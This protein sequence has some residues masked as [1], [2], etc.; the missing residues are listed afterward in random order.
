MIKRRLGE[1]LKQQDWAGVAIELVLVVV[2]VF[3]GIQV[4][5][6]ND[7]RRERALERSYVAR[8]GQDVR[9]DVADLDEV[10]R[11]SALRMA[12]LNQLLPKASGQPLPSGFDSARGRVRVEL[13]PLYD[14]NSRISPSFAL[15][16]LTPLDDSRSA[17][18]TMIST[19]AIADMADVATLRR[20]QDYY[21]AVDREV[22]FEVGLEQN[23]DKLIDAERKVGISPVK[24]MTVDQLSI[25]FATNPELLA[26]A[27]N[28][29]LY[30]NR[31]LKLTRELRA[32][33][34]SL[35]D[36]LQK[37]N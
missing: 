26:T 37:K 19:G 22:H 33:A 8:I 1:R 4:A 7:Q 10:I 36:Y 2:G 5:N 17:Y 6:W 21:A 13:V 31:H 12:L 14:N 11:V 34:Q 9:S 3:L 23:R 25:A 16:I 20:I 35:I 15:F 24:A 18:E 30:T 28:Y 27:Q 32:R 29:W